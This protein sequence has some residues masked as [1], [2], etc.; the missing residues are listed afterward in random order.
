MSVANLGYLHVSEQTIG[1]W[2]SFGTDV[3]GTM[4]V[5]RGDFEACTFLKVD[6]A[7]F[8]LMATPG[9]TD[10]LLAA[11]W[12]TASE[13]DYHALIQKVT[14]TGVA[15]QQGS[16]EDAALRC[17]TEFVRFSDPAGNC[18]ELYHGRTTPRECSVAFESPQ[19]VSRFVT[20]DMGL[21][22]V[23]LP[24]PEIEQVHT[25]YIDVLGFG[26]S[27]DL[28]LPAPAEGAPEMRVMFMHA[29]NPRHHSVALFNGPSP[30]GIVHM[31]LEV[32]SIDEV[33]ACL[34]RVNQAGLPLL[35]SLGRHCNDNMLSFY[36][37][38]PGG[39]AVE[40]GYDGLQLD[41]NEFTPTVSTEGDF[42]GHAYQM[43]G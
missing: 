24:A 31:M 13:D 25:F 33:G 1:S 42:W 26:D 38:G 19:G 7:P 34:D 14:A 4:N 12:E 30:V 5:P 32:T 37:F 20:G 17:V 28:H 16:A 11:G 8:R 22:H 29:N 36:V 43:P 10:R 40:Y 15:V 41:W 35:S 6:D 2:R 21:G 9:E 3:L 23:V 39:I 27:D 18:L